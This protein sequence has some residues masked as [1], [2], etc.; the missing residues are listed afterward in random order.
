MIEFA[1]VLSFFNSRSYEILGEIFDD[2][3]S[4]AKEKQLAYGWYKDDQFLNSLYILVPQ[5]DRVIILLCPQG[6]RRF[7]SL[8]FSEDRFLK[9]RETLLSV[10]FTIK[11]R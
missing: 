10:D 4:W 11:P 2:I 1:E 9:L 7:H 5:K 6:H 3:E 8:H